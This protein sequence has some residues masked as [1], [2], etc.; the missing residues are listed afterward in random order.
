MKHT[1]FLIE[2]L[3]LLPL[4]WGGNMMNAEEFNPANPPEPQLRPKYTL[5]VKVEPEGVGYASGSGRY[6]AG[7][8]V[9]LNTSG[10][11]TDYQF[12]CW[13]KDG[14]VISTNRYFS[15]TTGSQNETVTAVYEFIVFN[16]SSPQ[17]PQVIPGVGKKYTLTLES[18]PAE[19]CSFSYNSGTKYMPDTEL[20]ITAYP[21][22]GFSFLG[23]FDGETKVSESLTL[24]YTMPKNDVKFTARFIFVPDSPSEPQGGNQENVDNKPNNKE[25]NPTIS[26]MPDSLELTEGDTAQLTAT[27]TNIA[28]DAEILWTSSNEDVAFVDANGLVTAR[29]EGEATITA[30]CQGAEATATVKVARRLQPE[31]TI[32]PRSIELTKGDRTRLS[33]T[34]TDIADDVVIEWTSSDPTVATVDSTGLVTAIDEGTATITAS[35]EGAFANCEVKVNAKPDNREPTITIAPVAVELTAGDSI[36]LTV[37][38]TEV[39]DAEVEWSTSD[40]AIA[41]VDSTGLLTAIAEGAAVITATCE[42]V[43]ATCEVKVNAKPLPPGPGQVSIDE[44]KVTDNIEVF[45]LQGRKIGNSLDGL[46]GRIYIVRTNSSTVKIKL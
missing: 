24:P 18:Q 28:D 17:E 21:S 31:I 8:R 15:Y 30:K 16:P 25:E 5:T 36:Q 33:I 20:K 34:T 7:T 29:S 38:T 27:T 3:I 10:N 22:Q 13:Q 39:D 4:L 6:E 11:D 23:W 26:L 1:S 41:T 35:C 14:Q 43:S 44:V 9:S 19:A 46:T 2:L 42:G 12:K 45:D 40:S 32:S 37:T